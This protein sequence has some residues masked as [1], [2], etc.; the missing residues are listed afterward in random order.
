M[1]NVPI[2][3]QIDFSLTSCMLRRIELL[4][5]EL[6]MEH[7][8][9]SVPEMFFDLVPQ[10]LCTAGSLLIDDLSEIHRVHP[11][12]DLSFYQDRARLRA[13]DGDV[14]VTFGQVDVAYEDYCQSYLGIGRPLWLHPQT[15]RNKS[16]V[17]ESAWEDRSVRR[18]L[19]GLIRQKEILYVHP[20]MGTESVWRL[21]ALLKKSSRSQL[22]VIAPLPGLS[23]WVNDKVAFA[24]TV[25]RLFYHERLPASE[26][27]WNRST[28]AVKL[29]EMLKYC[30]FVGVKLPSCAGGEGNFIFAAQELKDASTI[31]ILKVLQQRL[32][33]QCDSSSPLL[34]DAWRTDVLSSPSV[35]I[36]IPPRADGPPI[37]EGIFNQRFTTEA[38]MFEGSQPARF[39]RV[40]T[41]EIVQQSGMLAT[42]YQRLGYLGRCSF[43]LII[44][45]KSLGDCTLEMIEC[46]GRWGGT[47]LPM[48]LMNRL[49]GDWSRH[50]FVI[51]TLHLPGLEK[52]SLNQVLEL[53]ADDLF[54]IR[55][56]LGNVM[57]FNPRRISA[58]SSI[59]LIILTGDSDDPSSALSRVSRKLGEGLKGFA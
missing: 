18:Q 29:K 46:N 50:H 22:K 44:I 3:K 49:F 21:A 57:L 36:W 45:G 14:L 4:A 13:G 16:R 42:L 43:D 7:P 12:K 26:L 32:P 38:G 59:D 19:V 51:Q 28:L 35:Q 33:R 11:E 23:H 2:V 48:T 56:G 54:D 9:F 39:P 8:E 37:I 55:T 40:L 30:R 47:S 10:S 41:E 27:A 17:A 15:A 24:D 20:H 5:V 53:L 1:R 52:L 31:D 25:T 34:I 58:R 6:L